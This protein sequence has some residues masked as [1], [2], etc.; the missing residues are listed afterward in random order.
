[1]S[2]EIDNYPY[3]ASLIFNMDSETEGQAARSRSTH[4]ADPSSWCRWDFK[5]GDWI[6]NQVGSGSVGWLLGG[7]GRGGIL[8]GGGSRRVAGLSGGVTL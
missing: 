5:R 2:G 3:A 6:G 1:M 7:T 8:D 4:S